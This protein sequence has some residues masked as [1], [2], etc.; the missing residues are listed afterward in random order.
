MGISRNRGISPMMKTLGAMS[1][2]DIH[3]AVGNGLHVPVMAAW[4]LY[5]LGNSVRREMPTPTRL[6]VGDHEMGPF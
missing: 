4:M 5:V 3:F 2:I 1:E 6:A